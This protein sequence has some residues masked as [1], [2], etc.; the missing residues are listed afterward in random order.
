MAEMK[1]TLTLSG[2][3]NL[4]NAIGKLNDALRTLNSIM[5]R[6]V[7]GLEAA[8]LAMQSTASSGAPKLGS[9]FRGGKGGK[10]SKTKNTTS[11]DSPQDAYSM[12]FSVFS[13]AP[14]NVAAKLGTNL[15]RSLNVSVASLFKFATIAGVAYF[16]ISELVK[17]FSAGITVFNSFAASNLS[18]KYATGSNSANQSAATNIANALGLD[19]NKVASDIQNTP[20]GYREF[21][22]KLE[23]IRNATGETRRLLAN[24][25]NMQDYQAISEFS[26]SDMNQIKNLSS[27]P[28]S[29][30]A[31]S[32]ANVK[33]NSMW[34]DSMH[35]LKE[36][37]SG[38]LLVVKGVIVV[39]VWLSVTFFAVFNRIVEY[40][41][42]AQNAFEKWFNKLFHGKL[43]DSADKLN[44]AS[45]ELKDA[46]IGIK[47][48]IYG[49]GERARGATPTAWGFNASMMLN[50]S[51]NLGAFEY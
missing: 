29:N 5:N 9:V 42:V 12:L 21:M 41:Q 19:P 31:I 14:R 1:L 39:I 50:N 48:G 24:R 26:T 32:E 7:V 20:G 49:G 18:M 10:G 8:V 27:Y 38:L 22:Y 30:K 25:F 45:K 2:V 40:L 44:N 33:L 51:R 15:L 13:G 43:N 36:A 46:A 34:A 11:E 28:E 4:T 35:E 6:T 17:A 16:A 3:S 47:E 23:A 37:F